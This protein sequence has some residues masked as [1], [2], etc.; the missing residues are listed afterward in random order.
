MGFDSRK[1]SGNIIGGSRL[2]VIGQGIYNVK[3]IPPGF[4]KRLPPYA[5]A[6]GTPPSQ[7]P[8]IT[9]IPLIRP[10]STPTSTPSF[11]SS[12]ILW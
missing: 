7:T 8:C 4:T 9:S 5:D 11:P 1:K 3:I 12:S 10:S 2:N 6:S